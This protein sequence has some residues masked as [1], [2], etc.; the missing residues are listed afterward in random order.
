MSAAFSSFESSTTCMVCT[1]DLYPQYSPHPAEALLHAQ[2]RT[3][4][5]QGQHFVV[6]LEACGPR[7]M[8]AHVPLVRFLKSGLKGGQL[9]L[10]DAGHLA[11][12]LGNRRQVVILAE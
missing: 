2:R 3:R 10:E 12:V 5:R 6:E 8:I 9:H 1:V 11:D 7:L 4:F